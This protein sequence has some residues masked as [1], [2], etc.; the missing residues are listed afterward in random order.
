MLRYRL[1]AKQITAIFFF[2]FFFMQRFC[3]V[4]N[5]IENSFEFKFCASRCLTFSGFRN[6]S[7]F[8]IMTSRFTFK[9]LLRSLVHCTK[10]AA[11]LRGVDSTVVDRFFLGG[12]LFLAW[13]VRKSRDVF[14][15]KVQELLCMVVMPQSVGKQ[16]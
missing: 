3:R 8:S 12:Q 9:C 7:I 16:M 10:M 13:L 11:G 14:D 6:T 2:F 15:D 4:R 5:N 1:L